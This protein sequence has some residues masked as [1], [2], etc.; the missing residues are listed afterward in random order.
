MNVETGLLG[1]YT[2]AAAVAVAQRDAVARANAD[3]GVSRPQFSAAQYELDIDWPAVAQ[4]Q[5]VALA[6]DWRYFN[7]FA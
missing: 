6:R 4:R 2:A 7:R 3:N 5:R 1:G